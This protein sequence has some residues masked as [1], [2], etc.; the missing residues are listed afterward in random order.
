LGLVG[1]VKGV[2][3]KINAYRIFVGKSEGKKVNVR[4]QYE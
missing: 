3:E 1:R 2:R 4:R